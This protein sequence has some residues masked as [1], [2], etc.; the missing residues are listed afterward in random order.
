MVFGKPP[1]QRDVAQRAGVSTA[2]VSYIMN[3]R[4]DRKNPVTD[5]TRHRVLEAARELGY[6][7]N[8]AA[9]SLRRRRT[10]C[11]CVVYSPPSSPWLERL[12]EQVHEAALRHEYSVITMPVAHDDRAGR[13]LRILREQY[14]DGAILVPRHTLP[15][16]ELGAL[17]RHGLGL[18]VFDDV[19][20]PD[21][22]DVVRQA[23]IEACYAAVTHLI[24]RG[25][26]RIGYFGHGEP[27][28]APDL[29]DKYLGYRRALADH[30]IPV[31][32][33]LA[34]A[35]ADSRTAAY[36]ATR[37]LLAREQPPTAVFSASDR[38]GIAAIWT[39]QQQG[40]SVPDD[41]AVVGVGNT[42]EGEVITP[43]LTSVGIPAF[44]FTPIVDRLFQRVTSTGAV[45]ETVMEASWELIVRQSS[46]LDA[47][48][49]SPASGAL[50]HGLHHPARSRKGNEESP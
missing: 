34:I 47:V 1:T 17:A 50:R 38:C 35:A 7:R 24:E 43:A 13:A 39:A 37:A 20:V 21:G 33:S 3:G 10:D 6:Q 32:D 14:V 18:V 8:H 12:T 28:P 42:D 44:D 22:F 11:V 49:K 4:R 16:E 36:Q 9:R 40:L 19:A 30:G 23:Q 41:L 15:I 46:Q 29:D 2:T 26:Q 31:D 27:G 5:E 25:H 45:P 48:S